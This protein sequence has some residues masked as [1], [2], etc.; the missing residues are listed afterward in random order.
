MNKLRA[1]AESFCA[2]LVEQ[3]AAVAGR[4]DLFLV[5]PFTLI[6]RVSAALRP[7]EVAIGAQN[8]HW[9]DAGAWTGEISAPQLREAGASFV[10]V[11]HSERRANFG[12]TDETVARKVAALARNG[13]AALI[14]IGDTAE[15]HEAGR[16]AAILAG[17]VDAALSGIA[18]AGHAAIAFAYE[19]VWAIGEHGTAADPGFANDMIASVAELAGSRLGRAVSV[20]YGGSV[21]RDNCTALAAE[22]DIDGLFIGRSAWDAGGLLAIA[23]MF[24]DVRY[25]R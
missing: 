5:P 12:E 10:E 9:A 2:T 4:V 11:G 24:A 17:Q 8:V 14:C 23:R 21:D 20:L 19:P 22:P 15:Q 13:L 3:A 16:S 7:I 6:E 1:D 18:D 25:A